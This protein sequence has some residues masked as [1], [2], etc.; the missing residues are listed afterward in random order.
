MRTLGQQTSVKLNNLRTIFGILLIA[1]GGILFLDRFLKTGWLSLMI[2]PAVG[3]FLYL[4]GIKMRN[5]GII[6][7]GGLIGGFGAGTVS[8]WGASI[9]FGSDGGFWVAH[10]Q[11]PFVVQIGLLSLFTGIGWI[12]VVMTTA[13]IAQKPIWWGLI[14]AGVLGGLG[15]CLLFTPM[16]WM[17]LV[18]Y[19]ALGTGVPLLFWGLTSRLFGL[20]IPGCLIST[21][22][23]GIYSA[24]K[25]PAVGNSLVQTGIMLIW[26]ALGWVLITTGAR[27]IRQQYVWWPLIPGGILAMVGMGLYIGGDPKHAL[28]FIGNT[29]SIALVIFGLYLLLMR[30]GIH[31]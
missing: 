15:A 4:W 13:A 20:I 11:H 6:L 26:F 19:L 10:L 29:G 14:P 17:D 27:V 25:T 5:V 24:W 28:G 1:V 31:H 16:R 18:L 23:A 9:Q 8:A 21:I 3:M 22:G 2:L 7:S 30:K 12:V